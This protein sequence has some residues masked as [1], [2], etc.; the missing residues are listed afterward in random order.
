MWNT[1]WISFERDLRTELDAMTDAGY[2]VL[3]VNPLQASYFRNIAAYL[4]LKVMQ[5]MHIHWPT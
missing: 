3:S 1:G 5:Q 2:Q 4:E